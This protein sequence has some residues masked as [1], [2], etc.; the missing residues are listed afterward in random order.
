ME[1]CRKG[2][3]EREHRLVG[4]EVGIQQREADIQVREADIQAREA[5]IQQR[6]A[7]IQVREADVQ[8]LGT[9]IQEQGDRH[10]RRFSTMKEKYSEVKAQLQ[11]EQALRANIDRLT[12][13]LSEEVQGRVAEK[14]LT[15]EAVE[16]CKKLTKRLV[17]AEA[18]SSKVAGQLQSAQLKVSSLENSSRMYTGH[19]KLESNIRHNPDLETRLISKVLDQLLKTPGNTCT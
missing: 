2:M 18:T 10:V 4:Q 7:D 12:N 17:V 8:K 11:G 15:A 3:E 13:T 19:H 16:S 5:D 9:D 1:V 6:D 14:L